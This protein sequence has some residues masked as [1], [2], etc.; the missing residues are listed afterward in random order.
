MRMEQQQDDIRTRTRAGQGT[1][2]TWV[3]TFVPSLLAMCVLFFGS[4]PEALANPVEAPADGV[5]LM[6][7]GLAL[8]YPTLRV[9]RAFGRCKRAGIR[10]DHW[11]GPWRTHHHEGID[12]GGLGPDGG[13]GSAIRSMTRAR[14]VEIAYGDDLPAKFGFIDTRD[15]DTMRDGITYPRAFAVAGYGLV[16]FFT[17]ARGWFRTGNMVVTV[18]LEG[19]LKGHEIRYMHLGAARPDLSVGDILE[20]GEELGVLGGTAVQTDAPHLH[21]DIRSPDGE[22][23]DVAPLI[24]LVPS[25]WCGVPRKVALADRAAFQAAARGINWRPKTWAPPRGNPDLVVES[26]RPLPALDLLRTPQALVDAKLVTA[27]TRFWHELFMPRPCS[28]MTIE[29]DF[30][31][32][33]YGGHAWKLYVQ[34]GQTFS[35]HVTSKAAEPPRFA[36]VDQVAGTVATA[37]PT[38]TPTLDSTL[39]GPPPPETR[40]VRV[41]HQDDHRTDFEAVATSNLLITVLAQDEPYVLTVTERCR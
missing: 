26:P 22:A 40:G 25:A 5:A 14:I 9:F 1:R 11:R 21:L 35:V 37:R 24:G 6:P 29:E 39:E 38:Y 30:S 23:V 8:P 12:L 19:R 7:N 36:L 2:K 3:H 34:K 10:P 31:S 32:G 20:P 28:S 15:G 16:R 41:T 33:A 4:S 13:L 17:R 18:G 27:G